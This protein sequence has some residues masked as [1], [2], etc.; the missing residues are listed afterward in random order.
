MLHGATDLHGAFH[1][2]DSVNTEYLTQQFQRRIL[3][4]LLSENLIDN[5]TVE[6]MLS[7]EHSGF[8]VFV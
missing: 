6:N 4:S 2:L 7:W 8:N 5:A 1:K 3:N